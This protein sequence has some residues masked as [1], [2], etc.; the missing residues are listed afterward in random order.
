M[1]S[2]LCVDDD[3]A[4][5][6]ITKKYLEEPGVLAVTTALSVPE[7]LKKMETSR[8]DA[9]VTDYQMP[10]M[11]GIEFIRAVRAENPH[12]PLILFTGKGR[13]DVVIEAFN[14]GADFYLRK[15]GDPKIQ[16]AL[17]KDTIGKAVKIQAGKREIHRSETRYRRLFETARDGILIL[18]AESGTITD[19]N[20]LV[21]TLLGYTRDEILGK[22]IW[23]LGVIRERSL[24]DQAAAELKK[25]GY[26]RYDDLPLKT[27]DGRDIAVEFVSN[28]YDAETQK[29][30]QINIR[31]ISERKRLEVALRQSELRY[32]TLAEASPDQIFIDGRDGT[33]QYVNATALKLLRLSYD[34][35]V[36]R[37]RKDFF[38]PEI[39]KAQQASLN[40]VFENG[41]SVRTEDKIQFG[42][43]ELWIDTRL[44]PLKDE[45]G[46]VTSVLGI[47]RD[48]SERKA[49]EDAIRTF[50]KD[51]ESKVTER[52]SDLKDVN[53]KLVTEIGIRLDAEKLLTRSV[54]EKEALLR[55][56]HHR[57][58]NNLQIII[59]L[60]NL[61]SRYMTD[62]ATLSA[63][64]ESQN[65][66]KV[67]AIVHEKL[68]QSDNL[69]QIELG[70]Y[71]RFLANSLFQFFGM[72]GKGLTF[73]SDIHDIFLAID[74]A[75]PVGL[76]VNELISNSLKYA[77]PDG[78]TGEIS[79]AIQ[80]VDRTLTILFKDNG[81]GIPKDFD[82][83]NATSLGLRLVITLV[84][85]L[86]G[87]IELDRSSGTAFTIIVK[88]KE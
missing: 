23:E 6:D 4:Y 51:L 76:I 84:D 9:V 71:L 21:L 38:P 37:P 82:W 50:S 81:V 56:V 80:R 16:F 33:I 86:D 3:A 36:G 25:T 66:I 28:A 68:Y 19:A 13:E 26:T 75:I 46:I 44:V 45:S 22:N 40:R 5:L 85:Q 67:M 49:A 8:F 14:C 53:L 39:F 17:L 35:V 11:N 65:R 48:I 24:A 74:S 41:E 58:K 1:I 15:S 64:R 83:R 42:T 54:G 59:S 57:V 79:L 32:R 63:F 18:D 69:S 47:A 34:Q 30:I 72:S 31:E 61:Q 88:E 52:T 78:K 60:L 20:P 73:T 29:V 27:K 77:F 87:T 10:V 70:E 12:L 55:E 7:A 2:V 62:E 43:N